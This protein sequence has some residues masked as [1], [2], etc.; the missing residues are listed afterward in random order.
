M[1]AHSDAYILS[2]T[3]GRVPLRPES[4]SNA[5]GD[6]AG[7]LQK[8]GEIT[9]AIRLA[10]LRRTVETLLAGAGVPMEVRAQLQSHGLGGVQNRHYDRHSY[11]AE[12]LKAL[13]LLHGLLVNE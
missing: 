10:D 3:N 1:A 13:Q 9:K 11:M 8:S 2:S 12:K 6:I 7:E 4:L 5:F